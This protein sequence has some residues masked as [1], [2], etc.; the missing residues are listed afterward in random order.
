MSNEIVLAGGSGLLGRIL[1]RYLIAQGYEVVL[2]SRSEKGCES[3]T[4]VHWDGR[5]LGDWQQCLDGAAAVV[6][7]AG[8]SVNCR[9][10]RRNRE[11]IMRSRVDSTRVLGEAIRACDEPPRMW[12]N[13]S[14]ATI[15]KHSFNRPMDEENGVIQGTPEAKD[16]FSVEV[17]K[18]WEQ[19]FDKAETPDTRKV[20]LR[21]AIV[22][23]GQS[24]SALD[25]L[26]R[27]VNLRLGGKMASGA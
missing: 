19:T 26:R 14:T 8:R 24:G 25:M 23:A 1:R 3:A 10:Y 4:W 16:E 27:L 22:L 5:T 18:A 7:L 11:Q 20:A 9:Y 2:L 12:L 21:T 15:Y 13:S 6:N 17:A